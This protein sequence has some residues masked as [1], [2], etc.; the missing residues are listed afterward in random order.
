MYPN[1]IARDGKHMYSHVSL[2]YGL[3]VYVGGDVAVARAVIDRFTGEFIHQELSIHGFVNGLNQ[4][5]HNSEYLQL[6]EID[7][8]IIS[9]IVYRY[10]YIQLYISMENV[11][12]STPCPTTDY[13]FIHFYLFYH[14]L[15]CQANNE[16][17]TT[18]LCINSAYFNE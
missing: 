3:Y 6:G 11:V 15:S 18:I 17:K 2:R 9:S 12:V 10:L 4:E 8:H 16:Q 5:A 1:F 13:D 14:R 7:P